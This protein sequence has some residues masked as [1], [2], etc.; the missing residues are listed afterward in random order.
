MTCESFTFDY[1]YYP[2][3]SCQNLHFVYDSGSDF[4]V[5]LKI[6]TVDGEDLS[7]LN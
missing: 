3:C 1:R 2:K 4:V 5:L 7:T 6:M